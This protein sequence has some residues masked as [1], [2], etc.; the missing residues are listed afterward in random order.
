MHKFI[1]LYGNTYLYIHMFRM[2]GDVM[3]LHAF[4]DPNNVSSTTLP[5]LNEI[6]V[7][8]FLFAFNSSGGIPKPLGIPWPWCVIIAKIQWASSNTFQ[9][10]MPKTRNPQPPQKKSFRNSFIHCYWFLGYIPQPMLVEIY[11]KM[12]ITYHQKASPSS[13]RLGVDL[14]SFFLS[15]FQ[16][17]K[18]SSLLLNPSS[19]TLLRLLSLADTWSFHSFPWSTATIFISSKMLSKISFAKKLL[20]WL[21][22]LIA[23]LLLEWTSTM[24]FLTT[25]GLGGWQCPKVPQIEHNRFFNFGSRLFMSGLFYF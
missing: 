13:P 16:Q 6:N 17:L 2:V 11:N 9:Q 15:F 3:H 23:F 10:H 14:S 8:K 1:N 21:V 12:I 20:S 7:E 22:I 24:C 19:L 25:C 18:L 5:T 4:T